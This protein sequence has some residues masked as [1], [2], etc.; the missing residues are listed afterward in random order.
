MN[1]IETEID[2]LRS[3]NAVKMAIRDKIKSGRNNFISYAYSDRKYVS[4]CK[5]KDSFTTYL[6][7]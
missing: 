3:F 7:N 4:V 5:N 2:V 1:Y 6:Q